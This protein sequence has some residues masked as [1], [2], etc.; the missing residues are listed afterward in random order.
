MP[1]PETFEEWWTLSEEARRKALADEWENFSRRHRVTFEF[2]YDWVAGTMKHTD[3]DEGS[4][5][6]GVA[7]AEQALEMMLRLQPS[8]AQGWR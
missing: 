3:R 1:V 8:L 6:D 7:H 5:R 2:Y 4:P